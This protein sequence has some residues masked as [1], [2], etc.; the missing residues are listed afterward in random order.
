VEELTGF[1]VDV[2]VDDEHRPS[3]LDST[4]WAAL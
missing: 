4:A 2:I 3:F 1:A